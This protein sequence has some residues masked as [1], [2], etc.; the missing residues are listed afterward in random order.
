[1]KETTDVVYPEVWE[2]YLICSA[3]LEHRSHV[4]PEGS[5]HHPVAVDREAVTSH[6]TQV[7]NVTLINKTNNLEYELN[8]NYSFFQVVEERMLMMAT[9]E[10]HDLKV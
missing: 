5:D 3:G 7:S 2:D 1:M 6:Q 9:T 10:L 4:G 8:K